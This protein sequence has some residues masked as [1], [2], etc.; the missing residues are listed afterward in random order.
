MPD[1]EAGDRSF[2][3]ALPQRVRILRRE[4]EERRERER[5]D[6]SEI[7]SERIERSIGKENQ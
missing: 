5:R 2:D 3:E 6:R 1:T 4:R 7:D